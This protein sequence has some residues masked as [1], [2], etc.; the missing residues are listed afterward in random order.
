V[1][2]HDRAFPGNDLPDIDKTSLKDA[3][4]TFDRTFM[5]GM[6]KNIR[7]GFKDR[8]ERQAA[9]AVDF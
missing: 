9:M 1:D 6:W 7:A 3:I 8:A 4:A 2:A 5:T